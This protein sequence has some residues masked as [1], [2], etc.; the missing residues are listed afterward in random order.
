MFGSDMLGVATGLVLVYI[1]FSLILTSTKETIEAFLKSRSKFLEQGIQ[2]I[3][4]EKGQGPPDLTN[5][6]EHP[7]IAALYRGASYQEAKNAKNLPAYIPAKS[8]SAAVLNYYKVQQSAALDLTAV[9]NV[10]ATKDT[11]LARAVVMAIDSGKNDLDQVQKQIEDWYDSVMDRVAGWYKRRSQIILF[12]TGVLVAIALNANS[13]IIAQALYSDNALRGNIEQLAARVNDQA[14]QAQQAAQPGFRAISKSSP[15][16]GTKPE[17][18]TESNTGG[19]SAEPM[20]NS[21]ATNLAATSTNS[22]EA[23]G[24]ST[25]TPAT[26]SPAAVASKPALACAATD[27]STG[28]AVNSAQFN[29]C[30]ADLD[31]RL[32]S[33]GIPIGWTKLGLARVSYFLCSAD[34]CDKLDSD[35]ALPTLYGLLL[36]LLGYLATGAALSLGAPFWFDVLNKIMV[37]R[38]TVKPRQK[39]QEEG[40]EDRAPTRAA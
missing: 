38:S 15:T 33:T 37:I 7:L 16:S 12:V 11:P 2:E 4:R 22:A 13:V 23:N 31:Q 27:G 20:S 25:G 34:K 9:R 5:F 32:R 3:F 6:Y 17:A 10:A 18:A 19:N 24:T 1:V 8:F 28:A 29:A 30:I 14:A 26:K 40:S 39:S 35:N 36:L 21:A